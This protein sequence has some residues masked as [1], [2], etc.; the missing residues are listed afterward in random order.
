M[1][2]GG[3]ILCL[4]HETNLVFPN[5][6]FIFEKSGSHS[7]NKDTKFYDLIS[8]SEAGGPKEKVIEHATLIGGSILYLNHETDLNFVIHHFMFEK[9]GAHILL[10]SLTRFSEVD[11]YFGRQSEP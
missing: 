7:R 4:N 5:R 9:S 2:I 3:S 6:H 1:L 10:T 11:L 8:V